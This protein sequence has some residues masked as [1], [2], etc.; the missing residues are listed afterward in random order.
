M[1]VQVIYRLPAML[2]HIHHGTKTVVQSL[3][4][5]LLRRNGKHVPQQRRVL[6]RG[7]RQGRKVPARN[8]QKVNRRLWRDVMEGKHLLILMKHRDR[9]LFVCDPAKKA[10]HAASIA[11]AGTLPGTAQPVRRY[12]EA[13]SSCGEGRDSR[14][15]FEAY[16]NPPPPNSTPGDFVKDWLGKRL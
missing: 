7:V 14:S 3:G 11:H 4:R 10:S 1:Q 13:D 8:D 16:H 15:S 6:S 5:G 12:A 2:S 9:D